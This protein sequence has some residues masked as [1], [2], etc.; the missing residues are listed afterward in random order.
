MNKNIRHLIASVLVISAF[1]AIVPGGNFNLG[2][3]EAQAST[4]KGAADGQLKSLYVYRSTGKEVQLYSN[5]AAS[6]ETE[7]TSNTDYYIQLKGSDT[8]EI[9]AEVEGDDYVAKIFTSSDK[10]A[11]GYDPSEIGSIPIDSGSTKI[12]IRT[13]RS[14]DDYRDAWD[15]KNVKK[16][17][18]TYTLH[19]YKDTVSSDEEDSVEY[20]YL[21]SIYLSDG[22]IDFSRS[23]TSYNINVNEDV[24]NI[25]VR[26]KPDDDDDLVEIN[27]DSV[28]EDGD[29]EKEIS[30]DKGKNT[31]E[32]TVENDDETTTY[33]LVINRGG[34]ISGS[35]DENSESSDISTGSD[36][37]L[38]NSGK[39]NVWVTENGKN[40]YIDG[41]GQPMKNK[42]WFDA[43]SGNDY[44]FDENG[45]AK[46]GW[47]QI[48]EK[49]Y[50]FNNSGQMQKGWI[51][52]N[53][54]WYFLNAAGTMVTGW[55]K[56]AT[57]KWYYLNND[58]SMKTGWLYDN[59]NWYLLNN[60]GSMVTGSVLVDGVPYNF[61]QNGVML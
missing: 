7:L 57:G 23:K 56:D 37:I 60:D 3:V 32:I 43:A 11:K 26:A 1:S 2:T 30:L 33:T 39:S 10:D 55:Y 48:N 50:Y 16:C 51:N 47:T 53:G 46:T 59:E 15:D 22:N 44:Y 21:R 61:A 19:I 36:S 20:P 58:G 45:Y 13:Y 6:K 52:D 17:L 29:Y 49:W 14:E 31:I 40:M 54:K 4:Y 9:D 42:W 25:L 8:V 35:S 34:S 12:Y 27:G 41:I 5:L 28:D 24:K 38:Y 18:K